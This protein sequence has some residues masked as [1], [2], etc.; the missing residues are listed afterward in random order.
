MPP[1]KKKQTPDE[2]RSLENPSISLSDPAAWEEAFGVGSESSSGIRIDRKSAMTYP[3]VWRA[4]NLIAGTVAKL[5]LFVYKQLDP[6]KERAIEHPAHVLLRRKWT[7]YTSAFAGKMALTASALLQGA[8][9]AWIVR[10]G[11]GRPRELWPLATE[12]TFPFWEDGILGYTTQLSANTFR[13]LDP[14][15]VL[16]VKGLSVD[17][18]T[19]YSVIDRARDSLGLGLGAA[20]YSAK[21]YSNG[22]EPRVI[23]EVP[24]QMPPQAKEEFLRQWN[25]MHN[26]LDNS[27]RTAILTGGA[28]VKAFSVNAKDAQLL[29][30]RQFEVREIANWFGV[31]PH[32]LGDPSRTAYASLEQE[33]QSFLDDCLDFWLCDWEEECFDK[34]LTE[35]EKRNETHTVEFLRQALVRAN[36]SE[37][38]AAYAT[39]IQSR[40]IRPNEARAWEN[41]NPIPGGDDFPLNVAPP[42]EPEPERDDEPEPDE[43]PEDDSAR[44][45]QRLAAQRALAV[46]GIRSVIVEAAGRAIGRLAYSFR[47]A[48][49]DPA[50][51]EKASRGDTLAGHAAAIRGML[52][53]GH[54]LARTCNPACPPLDDVLSDL[55]AAMTRDVSKTIQSPPAEG[56]MAEAIDRLMAGH[57][58]H[59]PAAIANR[60]LQGDSNGHEKDPLE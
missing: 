14:A 60:L 58:R 51:L 40:F 37:R 18:I 13:R 25:T 4:M 29:E 48:N 3:A 59:G 1:R 21:F 6:G 50:A 42:S 16:H 22:A 24:I 27:H 45:F 55:F 7:P 49:G 12:S 56:T 47:R 17:G 52:G 35:P 46:V 8:G 33:N 43:P 28:T 11:S 34:L 44:A 53:P 38:Y 31:P 19:P 36:M 39:G 20:K 30:S 26:G 10:D 23:I 41:L 5:P 15:D 2:T 32:K 54:T 57:E 9:Y